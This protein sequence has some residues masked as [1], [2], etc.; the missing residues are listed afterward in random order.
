MNT[1]TISADFHILKYLIYFNVFLDS[2]GWSMLLPVLPKLHLQLGLDPVQSSSLTSVV[3]M[4]TLF[5]SSAQGLISDRVGKTTTLYLS[6][7]T[8]ILGSLC[9]MYAIF[10]NS[11]PLFIVGRIIAAC[12]KSGMIISQAL[13]YDFSADSAKYVEDIGVMISFLNAAYVVGP[14]I[15]GALYSSMSESILWIACV[16]SVFS[17]IVITLIKQKIDKWQSQ[18]SQ[19]QKV[20]KSQKRCSNGENSSLLVHFLHLKFAFQMGNC[21]F[22]VYF[23]QQALEQFRFSAAETGFL[24]GWC[25]ILSAVTN[26]FILRKITSVFKGEHMERLL[27]FLTVCLSAGLAVWGITTSALLVVIS[28]T[29]ISVS[30]SLFLSII[31]GLI[32]NSQGSNK[33]T[34]TTSTV[35]ADSIS[36]TNAFTSSNQSESSKSVASVGT[37]MG[38]SSTVDR[39][40]R[41][42]SPMIG[43]TL[44]LQYGG[45]GIS[46]YS[47]IIC[48]YCF[49]LMYICNIIGFSRSSFPVVEKK[50]KSD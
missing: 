44:K 35:S 11:L 50:K 33:D 12:F 24:L 28:S 23:A 22:D 7:L 3:S 20:A 42:I 18:T 37:I 25:G 43:S 21:F 15:G 10:C 45:L 46:L 47:I 48:V 4:V 16:F 31:Q 2:V 39:A 13:L 6:A 17:I 34:A 14:I 49:F 32:A 19:S 29:A 30:S 38:Y 27:P 36:K 41:I 8:Q 5:A 26:I 1:Q 40:A 9:L